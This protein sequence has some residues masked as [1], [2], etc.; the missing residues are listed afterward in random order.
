MDPDGSFRGL[1]KKLSILLKFVF[2]IKFNFWVLSS[3]QATDFLNN[4]IQFQHYHTSL[5]PI[6]SFLGLDI[7]S[8]PHET[9]K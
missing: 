7:L 1:N 9:K 4:K 5:I 2:E 8:V 3:S 6:N